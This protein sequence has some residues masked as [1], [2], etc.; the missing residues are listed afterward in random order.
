MQKQTKNSKQSDFKIGRR[1]EQTFS[2][3]THKDG[4]KTQEKMLNI[5]KHQ[6]NTNKNH[7]GYHLTPVTMT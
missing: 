4:K 2:Q 3:R 6:G 7:M 5:T 1:S